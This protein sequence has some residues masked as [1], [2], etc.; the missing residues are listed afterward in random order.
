MWIDDRMK[1]W[2]P[3]LAIYDHIFTFLTVTVCIFNFYELI[4]QIQTPFRLLLISGQSTETVYL[5]KL[6][7]FWMENPMCTLEPIYCQRPLQEWK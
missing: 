4:D 1:K 3:N 2:L 7:G 6:L 5:E